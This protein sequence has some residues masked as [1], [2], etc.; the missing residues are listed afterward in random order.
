MDMES[1]S[2]S[3]ADPEVEEKKAETPAIDPVRRRREREPMDLFFLLTETI[4]VDPVGL[5]L[6]EILS[7]K[8]V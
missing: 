1:T 2:E 8:N 5:V 3:D 6:H 4:D 7:K